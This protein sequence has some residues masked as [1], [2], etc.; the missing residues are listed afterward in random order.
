MQQARAVRGKAAKEGKMMT[1]FVVV[2]GA[3]AF[4]AALILILVWRS[5]QMRREA[6]AGAASTYP[7]NFDSSPSFDTADSTP[8]HGDYGGLGGGESGG[9]G[10]G[11]SWG[12]DSGGEGAD[13]GGGDSGSSGSND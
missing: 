4:A 12:G 5:R 1:G 3:V 6:D 8:S 13:S 9:A 2:L 11:A 10:A 7:V